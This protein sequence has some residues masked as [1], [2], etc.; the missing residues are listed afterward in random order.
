MLPPDQPRSSV[1]L[2]PTTARSLWST[3]DELQFVTSLGTWREPPRERA[4]LLQRY[5]AACAHRQDWGQ[6]DVRQVRLQ[7]ERLLAEDD[8]E[9]A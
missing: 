7:I 4:P 3:E 2:S 8:S 1:H 9:T 6:I 5:L